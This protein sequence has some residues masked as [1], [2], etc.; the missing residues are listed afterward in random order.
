[1]WVGKVCECCGWGWMK[2]VGK[3]IQWNRLVG[4]V[5]LYSG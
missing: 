2:G 1:M 5:S 3:W 4:I